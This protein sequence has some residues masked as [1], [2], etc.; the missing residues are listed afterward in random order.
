[1]RAATQEMAV[2]MLSHPSC[3]REVALPS[4]PCARR[5]PGRI[6]LKYDGGDLF[7]IG[8]VGVAFEQAQIGDEMVLIVARQIGF[9]FT[10]RWPPLW[11]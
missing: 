10:R 2:A 5:F 4:S 9:V 11:L 1:M 7:P 3:A 8:L 6:D